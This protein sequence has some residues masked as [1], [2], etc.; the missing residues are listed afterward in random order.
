MKI[1]R[2]LPMILI[3]GG[4]LVGCL[5]NADISKNKLMTEKV[6]VISEET[7]NEHVK[8][9]NEEITKEEAV[10]IITD[11]YKKYL[12][13]K[14]EAKKIAQNIIIAYSGDEEYNMSIW[15]YVVQEGDEFYS[16]YIDAIDGKI[17]SLNYKDKGVSS[18]EEKEVNIEKDIQMVLEFMQKNDIVE[19]INS[20]EFLRKL[21]DSTTEYSLEF[22][23][24]ESKMIY[25][26]V[27]NVNKKILGF[28][29]F[30]VK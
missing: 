1:K 11:A 26:Q 9:D 24:G 15:K 25:I 28:T 13:K 12:N 17:W 22:K 21:G 14:V 5:S 4:L 20:V 30:D 23:Y 3:V 27:D 6:E 7:Q 18:T 8:I 19:N 10:E 29:I 16:A 2:L